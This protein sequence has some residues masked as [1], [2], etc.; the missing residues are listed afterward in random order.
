MVG[1]DIIS[2]GHITPIAFH[3]ALFRPK[4]LMFLMAGGGDRPGLTF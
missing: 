1:N 4:T 3:L 2:R